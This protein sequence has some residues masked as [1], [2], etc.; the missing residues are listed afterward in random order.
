MVTSVYLLLVALLLA[1]LALVPKLYWVIGYPTVLALIGSSLA[2]GSVSS[3]IAA[4]RLYFLTHVTPHIAL[5]AAP[6]SALILGSGGVDWLLAS[7]IVLA[8]MWLSGYAIHRGLDSD[9]VASTLVSLTASATVIALYYAQR[10]VGSGRVTQLILGDPL[11]VTWTEGLTAF[12][13]G[14]LVAVIAFSVAREVFYI[15]VNREMALVSGLRTWA[16]DF[17]LYTLIALT[18]ALMLRVT[19]FLVATVLALLPGAIGLS[20]SRGSY[21]AVIASITIALLAS[22]IG[23]LASVTLNIPPSGLTGL[24]LVLLFI[25]VRVSRVV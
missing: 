5:L 3:L 14:L 12:T 23:L 25:L 1:I 22:T 17:T 2:Y 13:A 19:G 7:L 6:I 10:L 11:L 20:L 24:I 16:Y 15:G 18:V 21:Q 8:F 4:R 9:V